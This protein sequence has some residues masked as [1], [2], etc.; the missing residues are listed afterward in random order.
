MQTIWVRLFLVLFVCEPT[1]DLPMQQANFAK[2]PN[3]SPAPNWPAYEP[4]RKAI[5][6]LGFG[7]NVA[8]NNVV[9]LANA[10][11]VDRACPLLDT[12]PL[13]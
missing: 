7:S 4:T 10:S 11:D 6:N 3:Q 2:Q 12:L 1:M 9:Q 5:A 8:L 13:A